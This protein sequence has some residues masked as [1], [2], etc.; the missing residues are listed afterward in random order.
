MYGTPGFERRKLRATSMGQSLELLFSAVAEA[1]GVKHVALADARGLPL[2]HHGDPDH[3]EILAAYGPLLY[4]TLDAPSRRRVLE[5][6]LGCIP[7][8]DPETIS[9]RRIDQFDEEL[10]LCVL[11]ERGAG[12]DVALNRAIAGARRILGT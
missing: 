2:A 3:C 6:L 9:V 7:N 11:G 8:A 5:S 12:K 4:R 10:Y 1:H